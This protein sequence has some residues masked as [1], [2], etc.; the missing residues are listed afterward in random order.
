[1]PLDGIVV[2]CL[3]NEF[4]HQLISSKIEKVYQPEKDELILLIRNKGKN[5]RLLLSASSNNPRIHF[6]TTNKQNPDVPPMFCM[7]LRKHLTGGKIIDIKQPNF[8]RIVELIIE[9]YNELGDLTIKKLVIEIMGRHSNIILTDSDDKIIDSIKHIDMSISSVRQI[10][11]GLTYTLPPSQGKNNPMECTKTDILNVILNEHDGIKVD[12]SIVNHFTGISPLIAREICHLAFNNTDLYI[13]ELSPEDK[14][15][16]C[17]HIFNLF[18]QI[19]N[20][21]FKP[22]ILTD[23]DTKKISDFSALPIKQYSNRDIVPYESINQVL[24]E[25]YVTRDLQERIKQKSTDL[26]KVISNNLDRCR[27]KLA[28]QQ[29][30]LKEVENREQFK[31]YGNLITANIYRISKGMKAVEVENFYDSACPM[32]SIPLDPE[33]T[34]SENAQKYFTKYTK[35][36][37]AA[38][39]V[40]EQM[41]LTLEEIEYLESAFDLLSRAESE[42]DINEIRAELEEQGYVKRRDKTRLKKAEMP[43][44]PIQ[45][46]SSDGFEILVGRNNKQNDYLT[47]RMAHKNDLWLHT[48]NIPGSHTIIRVGNKKSIPDSTLFEAAVLAAYHSKGKTSS[49]VAVDYTTV[50]NV[51]KPSGAKPGM[52]IYENYK[53]IYVTPD[54]ELVEKLRK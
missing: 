32:I 5:E 13:G 44:K 14:Q 15:H 24:D 9:C 42:Q 49:N 38:E 22:I 31:L 7:L 37:N 46:I 2:N 48:K 30:K 41:K 36:K 3:V 40:S 52:V 4:H 1:M 21:E 35:A 10:L 16:I 11:P 20:A 34:A 45:F 51:K 50:N 12:K 53:T 33:L 8:E 43:S 18:Q 26:L 19:K 6:T 39:T 17:Q 28:L 47:L 25:F 54:E 23:S 29:E 27:K